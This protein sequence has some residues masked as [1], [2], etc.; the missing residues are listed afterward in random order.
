MKKLHY[1]FLIF[2]ILIACKGVEEEQGKKENE[3]KIIQNEKSKRLDSLYTELHKY[4]EFN[5]NVLVAEGGNTIFQKSYGL[6][7]EET[8]EKL[9]VE[10]VFE[11]ASVSKQFT[12]MGIVQ[13]QKAG[14]LSYDDKVSIYIPELK[15]YVG[16]TIKNLLTHTGGLPNYMSI[17]EKNWDK[18]IFATNDGIIQLFE[19]LQ[20]EKEFKPN[21]KWDYSN[22]GYLVLATII[23][24]VS[25]KSFE[26][27]LKQEIFEPL[28]MNNTF[29][30][31]RRF[32]P[33]KVNNYAQG[34]IYSDSLKRKIL[35]DE[36]G[37]DFF[38][39]YLDG[40]VG[41]GMVSSNLQDLLKWDRALYKNK[42]INDEDRNIIFSS[43]KITD[44]TETNYGFGWFVKKDSTYGKRV[45]HSGGWAGYITYIERNID[46]DKT[47]IIL[48]N[49][50]TGKIKIPSKDTRKIV[51]GSPIEKTFR[52]PEKILKSYIGVYID[53]N[54][55]EDELIFDNHSLWVSSGSSRLSLNPISKTKFALKG[56]SPQV[57]YEFILDNKGKV[58]KIRIQQ[59]KTGVDITKQRKK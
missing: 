46:N 59:I 8:K 52:L 21:E 29:T 51:Y 48:Q 17:T 54:G 11:L 16:I 42:I 9:N 38:Y 36:N 6:A 5:G 15:N 23:E 24:R 57:T 37:K 13:L 28:K 31:R 44:T 18:S 41:D 35:P 53:E 1:I 20:P 22:T 49:N 43:Y 56:F 7:N 27:Y 10:S 34:Y 4:G 12:A 14:K 55:E 32:K 50:K 25:G 47:V 40:I 30:Y 58:Q 26:E 3:F 33:M 45:Y 2:S 39:V 19:K